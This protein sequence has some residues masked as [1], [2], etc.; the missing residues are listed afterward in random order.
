MYLA[1]FKESNLLMVSISFIVLGVLWISVLQGFGSILVL[2]SGFIFGVYYGTAISCITLSLGACLT[3]IIANYFFRDLI[4]EKFA[5]R[6]KF[7]EKI[8]EEKY[9]E[10]E[11]CLKNNNYFINLIKLILIIKHL[12]IYHSD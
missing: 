4:E 3:Y 5:N 12:F 11:E 6:F 10:A 1:N 9:L 7:I 8:I 2:A